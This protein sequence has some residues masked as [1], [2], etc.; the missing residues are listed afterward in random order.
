MNVRSQCHKNAWYLSRLQSRNTI[1]AWYQEILTRGWSRKAG[2]SD[3]WMKIVWFVI[4]FVSLMVCTW[5]LCAKCTCEFIRGGLQ[6][7]PRNRPDH[8]LATPKPTKW[9]V[10]CIS[11]LYLPIGSPQILLLYNNS[12]KYCHATFFATFFYILLKSIAQMACIFFAEENST[13]HFHHFGK[14]SLPLFG[15]IFFVT[16]SGVYLMNLHFVS[17][18]SKMPIWHNISGGATPPPWLQAKCQGRIDIREVIEIK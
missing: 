8:Q 7:L 14:A 1:I 3:E 11:P 17:S 15:V 16:W 6:G 13:H 18:V 10:H 5:N 4:Y 2:N 9:G 12:P